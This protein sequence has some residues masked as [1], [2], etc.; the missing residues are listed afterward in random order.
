MNRPLV[1]KSTISLLWQK[2]RLSF[3]PG[4][5]GVWA[6]RCHFLSGC[7][8]PCSHVLSGALWPRVLP[9]GGGGGGGGSASWWGVWLLEVLPWY[10]PPPSKGR[11]LPLK[12][13]GPSLQRHT[14]FK[15]RPPPPRYGH[16]SWRYASYWNAY[17]LKSA[18]IMKI[19]CNIMLISIAYFDLTWWTAYAID[20]NMIFHDVCSFKNW[21]RDYIEAT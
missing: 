5:G 2:L 15:G 21:S 18:N 3:C 20:I 19:V 14:P 13:D 11:P 8:V 10:K 9:P 17:L 6:V 1:I 12:T 7:L 16:G 4:G